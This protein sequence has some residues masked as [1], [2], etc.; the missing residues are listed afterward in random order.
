MYMLVAIG[1]IGVIVLNGYLFVHLWPSAVR[2]YADYDSLYLAGG[3]VKGGVADL[4]YDYHAQTAAHHFLLPNSPRSLPL[5]FNHLAY[6]AAI[7]VPFAAFP[8]EASLCLWDF[9]N[10]LVLVLVGLALRNEL[11]QL[12]VWLILLAA[13]AFSPNCATLTQGQDSILLLALYATSYLAMKRG[14]GAMAGASL[15]LGLFKYHLILPFVFL[16]LMSRKWSVV[17]GFLI[18]SLLPL[19]GSLALCGIHG[20]LRYFRLMAETRSLWF[21][22][23]STMPN[24]HGLLVALVP[25]G[26]LLDGL[27]LTISLGAL[28]TAAKLNFPAEKNDDFDLW[29][30]FGV[31]IT[32]L[33]SFH[34]YIHDMSPLFL[35]VALAANYSMKHA[36]MRGIKSLAITSGAMMLLTLFFML[37]GSQLMNFL[38]LITIT[39]ASALW[40]TLRHSNSQRPSTL[41][42]KANTQPA[43]A[44]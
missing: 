38:G 23:P 44:I 6:E 19:G 12:P 29:F 26:L 21:M 1:L 22:N 25:S 18:G 20:S 8:F 42:Q 3:M 32:Y 43:S 13:F 17:R 7:F 35:A 39:F 40:I 27:T 11:K 34:S 24:L 41:M 9:V 14:S 30:A 31:V 5:P 2:G 4:L 28:L 10:I 15:A 16:L 36:E 33:V 37:L